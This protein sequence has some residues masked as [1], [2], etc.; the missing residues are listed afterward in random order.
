M[1]KYVV[2][3]YF[4]ATF[5]RRVAE[6]ITSVWL[7]QGHGAI[8]V[9]GFAGAIV[10]QRTGWYWSAVS[11]GENMSLQGSE[12]CSAYS[13]SPDLGYRC[14]LWRSGG[15][16]WDVRTS[17][18]VRWKSLRDSQEDKPSAALW[19]WKTLLRAVKTWESCSHL[20]IK[21]SPC[22]TKTAI[23]AQLKQTVC[24]R[25]IYD[26]N[27]TFLFFSLCPTDICSGFRSRNFSFKS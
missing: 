19:R 11:C 8:P 18:Q 24:V 17:F 27:S 14:C 2:G 1:P 20:P 26:L 7:R 16:N 12:G 22:R 15:R 23:R 21:Q 5:C 10:I 9:L 4:S 13:A 3:G 25:W 6:W